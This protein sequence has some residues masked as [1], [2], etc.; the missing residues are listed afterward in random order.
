MT[1]AT[2]HEHEPTPAV[3]PRSD[4]GSVAL[5]RALE[6]GDRGAVGQ[7]LRDDV[8]VVP[9]LDREDGT[10]QVQVFPAP[11][12]SAEPYQLCLFS[13]TQSLAAF[14]QDAPERSFSMR[15]RDSMAPFVTRHGAALAH[16]VIDPAGPSPMTFGTGE[17]LAALDPHPPADDPTGLFDETGSGISGEALHALGTVDDPGGFRGVGIELNLPEHWAVIELDEPERRERQIRDIVKQQTA[18]LGDRSAPLR[19]DLREK[20]IEVADKAE[21]AGGKVMAYLLLPGQEAALALNLTLYWH[22]LGPEAGTSTHL[23]RVQDRIGGELGPDDTLTRTETLSGP[24]LRHVRVGRGNEEVGGQDLPLLLVDYW[25]EAP[26]R[27]S[28]AR[29]SFST[30][31]V[32]IRDEML[33]LTDK[34]L[35]STEWILGRPS[36]EEAAAPEADA[37]P[38]PAAPTTP[39]PAG[40]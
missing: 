17:F 20:L 21:A 40:V 25:A 19:R 10:P 12:G 34:V 35:F 7:A 4:A 31:H 15:R 23:Q 30:P 33:R 16:V 26:G 32:G 29:L 1:E 3:A 14:L 13:T 18:K 36:E 8:V 22:D 9:V 24:F 2:P 5:A 11:E 6:A 37:A 38:D 28:V 39:T 27:Q